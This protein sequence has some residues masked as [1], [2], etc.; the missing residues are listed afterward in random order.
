M[1]PTG[2]EKNGV[3]I[4]T[5]L[6]KTKR[7]PKTIVSRATAAVKNATISTNAAIKRHWKKNVVKAAVTVTA[8]VA[9]NW[10]AVPKTKSICIE[11]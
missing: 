11:W 4:W 1:P 5:N 3:K 7:K 10:L 6:Q 9:Q 2:I 8:F